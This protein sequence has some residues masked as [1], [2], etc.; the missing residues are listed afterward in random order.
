MDDF[1]RNYLIELSNNIFE[2]KQDISKIRH[3]ID[4]LYI[5]VMLLI[6]LVG[7]VLFLV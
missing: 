2:I 3:T 5:G 1:D 4:S 6:V 7:L